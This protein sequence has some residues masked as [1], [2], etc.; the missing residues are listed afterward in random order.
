LRDVQQIELQL[1]QNQLLPAV[2][3]L[4]QGSHDVG[5][6]TKGTGDSR[7][8][9]A[10]FEV[11]VRVDVP[12]QRS[13]ARGRVQTAQARI[14]QLLQQ[15]RF[16]VDS[17]TAEVQ[18][19]LSALERAYVQREQAARASRWALA[20]EKGELASF[21]VGGG[22]LLRVVLREQATFEQQLLEVD[23]NQEY[24][25]ALADYQA[26]LGLGAFPIQVR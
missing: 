3:G 12:V 7:L 21:L 23:A 15:E 14:A 13:D 10:N 2:D 8:D 1:A 6:P 19:T 24:F 20:V 22:D 5:R 17:I 26:A 16:A 4:I 11:G 9:R 18:D 25:R